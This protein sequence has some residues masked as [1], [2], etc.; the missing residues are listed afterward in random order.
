M[1][2]FFR[3]IRQKLLSQNRLSKYLLYAIGE[4]TL[5]VIGILIA[6]QI[7]NWNDYRKDRIAEEKLLHNILEDLN[8]DSA[9]FDINI[10]N[11]YFHIAVLDSML[12]QVCFNPNYSTADF[13]RQNSYFPFYGKF[14]ATKGT[15][16]ESLSSGNLSLIVSDSLRG[17]ILAYYEVDLQT[18]GPD[19]ILDSDMEKMRSSWNDFVSYSREYAFAFGVQTNFP[20]LQIQAISNNPEYRK[21][22]ILKRGLMQA[23]IGEWE[24]VKAVNKELR[25]FVENHLASMN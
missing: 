6:L 4:I 24:R 18:L 19:L 20:N 1:V 25:H 23:Q 16:L 9:V 22:L 13:I 11:N 8:S 10:Q 14:L 17:A 3:R 5:V 2:N 7:N 15:Y 12:Y 21:L